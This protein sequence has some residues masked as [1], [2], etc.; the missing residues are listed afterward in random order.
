M[1]KE[2]IP[3]NSVAISSTKYLFY[4]YKVCRSF[5]IIQGN[6]LGNLLMTWES[7]FFNLILPLA[8][9][10]HSVKGAEIV[11]N[12]YIPFLVP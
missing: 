3:E 8:Q 12:T 10:P 7:S 11:W 4:A 5:V 9:P 1:Q 2:K 6:F